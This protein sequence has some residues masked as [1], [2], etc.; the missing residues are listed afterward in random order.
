MAEGTLLIA[1]DQPQNIRV[2]YELLTAEGYRVLVARDGAATLQRVRYGEPE[3]VLLDVLMPE[4][5]GFE[6]C[7][8]LKASPE[9]RHLP[10]LFMTALAETESKVEGLSLGASDYI[11]KPFQ[12]DEVLARVRTH[13]QISRLQ[14]DLER[15]NTELKAFSHTVAHDL[16]NPLSVI[17]GSAELALGSLARQ[18][19]PDPRLSRSLERILRSG[20]QM[21]ET[22]DALLL[23]AQVTHRAEVTLQVLP[24]G[25]L[26][27]ELLSGALS[28]AVTRLEATIT[29][30]DAWPDAIG[31]AA[32]VRQVWLNYLDNALKY[33][34]RPPRLVLGCQVTGCQ[35]RFWVQDNGGGLTDEEQAQLF[36]PFSR[37]DRGRTPGHGLGLTIVRQI[38]EKLGGQAGVDSEPGQGSRFW[39]TLPS[40]EGA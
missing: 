22:I 39:F 16:K 6:V 32:W 4:L 11:T 20:L 40:A 34:G 7:R 30:P 29:L 37:L 8:R 21:A 31:H 18:G 2:L 13:L 23:L 28:E 17:T 36:R 10:I 19:S 26:L 35:V 38:I 1:D 27:E 14:R 25:A 5:D 3:L 9:H 15:R 33:G 12:V 24:T